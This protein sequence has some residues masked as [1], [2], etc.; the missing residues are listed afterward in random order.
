MK[1]CDYSH[2]SALDD[3]YILRRPSNSSHKRGLGARRFQFN[4]IM[5]VWQQNGFWE[6]LGV[7]WERSSFVQTH[8]NNI[9][10]LLR[11]RRR[12]KGINKTRRRDRENDVVSSPSN[13]TYVCVCEWWCPRHRRRTT[14]SPPTN[15]DNTI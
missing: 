10:L 6:P 15:N 13:I 8:R 1:I 11:R 2:K 9:R 5:I 4:I 14:H 3:R 7:F 12:R